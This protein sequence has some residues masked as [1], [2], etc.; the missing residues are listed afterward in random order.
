MGSAASYFE[1]RVPEAWNRRLAEQVARG[2]E[3]A[4]LLAKMRAADFAL[5]I[6]LDE[7]E[8]YHLRVNGG[9]MR[10][11]TASD[12][13]PLVTLGLSN[14][15]CEQLEAT[16]GASPMS[17]LGGVAGNPDFV[18]TP[19]RLDALRAIEGTMR[20]E[21]SGQRPWGVVLHFGAPP[22]PEVTTKVAI[23]DESFAQLLAG[24]LDLQGAFM[25]GKLLLDGNVE[26]PMKMA[27]A[28]MTPA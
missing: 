20:I 21:V 22:I 13:K 28:I 18:L 25:G 15:D 10:A 16:V 9:T 14:G 11:V 23:S 26:V 3:G 27:M 4:D 19:A 2:A 24:A 7:G 17:L 1:K 6:A 8:R 12:P 5:E